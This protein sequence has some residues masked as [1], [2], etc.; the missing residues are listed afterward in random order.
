METLEGFQCLQGD[1]HTPAKSSSFLVVV[2]VGG[3]CVS[4]LPDLGP[5]NS[6]VTVF[7]C[8]LENIHSLC[9]CGLSG[10]GQGGSGAVPYTP[11]SL[12]ERF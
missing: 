7:P 5:P 11:Y 2:V 8:L 9:I 3:D 12:F 1:P 4:K 6:R 10:A